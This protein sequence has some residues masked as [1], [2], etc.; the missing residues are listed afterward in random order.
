MQF[1]R[2]IYYGIRHF[3]MF[4]LKGFFMYFKIK[5]QFDQP[6]IIVGGC[7]RSGTTLLLSI[8]SSHPDIHAIPVETF[9]FCP[10]KNKK[11]LYDKPFDMNMFYGKYFTNIKE[12]S[13]RWCEKTPS[14]VL[15]FDKI[16]KHFNNEVK[17]IHIVRDGRDVVLS[18]HPT[19]KSKSWVG[20]ERWINDVSQGL[21]VINHENVYTIRYEDLI[22]DY[23]NSI[24]KLCAFLNLSVTDEILHWHD[25][26]T[27]SENIAWDGKVTPIKPSS[28]GKWREEKFKNQVN[29]LMAHPTA[30]ELLKKFNYTV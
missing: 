11:F 20:P 2:S 22:L 1:I 19:N 12:S 9:S 4:R 26:T 16:L 5:K 25:H 29:A 17:I 13:R 8:L 30:V 7:G 27:V 23:E 21:K 15:F 28:I 24:R 3:F 14:N 6:P 10:Y 18:K